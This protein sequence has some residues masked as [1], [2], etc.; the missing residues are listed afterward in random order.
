LTLINIISHIQLLQSWKGLDVHLPLAAP[1]VIHIW[2]FQ[3]Q[4]SYLLK[5]KLSDPKMRV[6]SKIKKMCIKGSYE[7][8]RGQG[9]SSS[10]I[11]GYLWHRV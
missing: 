5:N 4:I 1:G 3:S 6:N 2:L 9:V 10:C 11:Q 8:E 7:V